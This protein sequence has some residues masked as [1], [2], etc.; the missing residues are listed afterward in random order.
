MLLFWSS[1]LNWLT[2]GYDTPYAHRDMRR[3]G[4]PIWL[5]VVLN[6]YDH[7]LRVYWC[8]T[9]NH[10]NLKNRLIWTLHHS[11]SFNPSTLTEARNEPSFVKKTA[12]MRASPSENIFSNKGPLTCLQQPVTIKTKRLKA[13]NWNEMYELYKHQHMNNYIYYAFYP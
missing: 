6:L 2:R 3:D 7:T 12:R 9:D 11:A 8:L 13:F 5:V 10:E 1:A 4:K